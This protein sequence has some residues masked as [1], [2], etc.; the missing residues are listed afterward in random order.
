MHGQVAQALDDGVALAALHAGYGQQNIGNGAVLHDL[1]QIALGPYFQPV[2]AAPDFARVVVD[3][4]NQGELAC[5]GNGSGSLYARIARAIN[6]Q[7]PLLA[8][9]VAFAI[10]KQGADKGAVAAH[11]QQK[12][13]RLQYGNAA[14]HMGGVAH[15]NNVRAKQHAIQRNGLHGS[16]HGAK[17]RVAENGAVQAPLHHDGQRQQGR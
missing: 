4:A 15:E 1:R 3:K 12:Q 17:A 6:Q 8:R 5:A 16:K 10:G 2:D 11:E 9:A 13:Q 7:A 14:R